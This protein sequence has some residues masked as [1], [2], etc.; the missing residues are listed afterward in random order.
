M[1]EVRR[2]FRPEERALSL[3]LN[4][5]EG[6]RDAHPAKD[7]LGS[8][9]R[10]GQQ[11]GGVLEL[12]T[13]PTR[14]HGELIVQRFVQGVQFGAQARDVSFGPVVGLKPLR[15]SHAATVNRSAARR[16]GRGE[17]RVA[18]GRS[19]PTWPPAA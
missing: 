10:I 16:E 3:F 9:R 15:R 5:V 1:R 7:G 18:P 17:P 14:D 6:E 8:F 12:L 11:A 13:H 2:S 4:R 19:Q